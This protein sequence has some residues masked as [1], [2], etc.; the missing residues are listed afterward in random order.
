MKQ[1]ISITIDEKELKKVDSIID[2]LFIRNRSQAIEYL[3][4]KTFE[5]KKICVI[6]GNAL[7]TQ[8]K[9]DFF[10]VTGS[11]GNVSVIEWSVKR[12]KKYGFTRL[13][14]VGDKSVNS[15][16]FKRIMI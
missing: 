1:K 5:K 10:R 16:I 6:L 12:L 14:V 15:E 13:F 11:L 4:K 2:R 9:S 3:I 8:V 7:A